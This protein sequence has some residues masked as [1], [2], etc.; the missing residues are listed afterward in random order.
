M[1]VHNSIIEFGTSDVF[2][3]PMNSPVNAKNN[4]YSFHCSRLQKQIESNSFF[5]GCLIYTFA[6]VLGAQ[7]VWNVLEKNYLIKG[8]FTQIFYSYDLK[9]KKRSIR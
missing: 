4:S 6:S 3:G 9:L 5:N 2:K 7:E 8:S 1:M